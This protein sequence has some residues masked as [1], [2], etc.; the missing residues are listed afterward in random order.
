MFAP[1]MYDNYD[2]YRFDEAERREQK[3]ITKYGQAAMDYIEEYR[4]ARWVDK[5]VELKALEQARE[6][7]RPYWQIEDSIWSMYPPELKA[8]SDQIKLMERTDPERA[9]RFLKQYPMILR[10]RELIAKYKKQMREMNSAIRQA[11]KLYYG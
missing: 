9:R 4:A 8:M 2:K 11:Y 10:A 3:F 7:L 5:P 6:L 1:D